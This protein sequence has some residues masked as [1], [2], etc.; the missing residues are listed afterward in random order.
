MGNQPTYSQQG[1]QLLNDESAALRQ[2][3]RDDEACWVCGAPTDYRKCK[4]ICTVCGF[5]RD[6]SDP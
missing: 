2:Q 1:Q 3:A 5:M 6:C 4:I